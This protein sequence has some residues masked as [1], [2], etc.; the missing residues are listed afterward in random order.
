M[1]AGI[2]L[3]L[4]AAAAGLLA[5][6]TVPETHTEAAHGLMFWHL[7]FMVGSLLLFLAVT[8]VRWRDWDGLAKAGSR[9]LMWLAAAVF[10]IGAAFGGTSSTTAAR[11]LREIC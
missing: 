1:V 8:L 11:A 7:G 4:L 2:V 5:F 9:F 3:G 6:F 10:V